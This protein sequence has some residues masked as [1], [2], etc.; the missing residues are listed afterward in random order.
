MIIVYRFDAFKSALNNVK[1]HFVEERGDSP[2]LLMSEIIQLINRGIPDSD[3]F[4]DGEVIK[5]IKI[6]SDDNQ[7]LWYQ[8]D[9]DSVM[10]F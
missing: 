4:S 7:G 6:M 9:N 1:D 10:F 3:V 8:E 5:Q 2:S